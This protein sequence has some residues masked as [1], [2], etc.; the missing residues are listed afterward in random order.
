[1]RMTL[2]QRRR[3]VLAA[4]AIA[5]LPSVAFAQ[6]E[7]RP[8]R[9]AIMINTDLAAAKHLIDA[10]KEKMVERGWREGANI[11]YISREARGDNARLDPLAA[12]LV[13]LKPDL[14]LASTTQSAVAVK[15]YTSVIP[16]VFT[17]VADPV[18]AGLAAS[19]SRPG[20]NATGTAAG[21][22][23]GLNAKRLQI[24][25]EVFPAVRRVAVFHDPSDA[26]DVATVKQLQSAA[27]ELKLELEPITARRPEDFRA[28]FS[29]LKGQK[30]NVAIIGGSISN[31]LHR[32]PIADLAREHRI[33]TIY[34]NV[35]GVEAG[36][37]MS[38]GA[39]LATLYRHAARYADRILRGARPAELPVEQPP[40]VEL[41]INLKTARAL[42]IKFPQQILV[43]A[44]KVIE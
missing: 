6:P 1:D 27:T 4:G 13:G 37:L 2:G 9:V 43:R 15:K 14:I 22:G 25:K 5:I 31:F 32:K 40:I 21:F 23:E 20:G 8:V 11:N 26:Q 7:R 17:V 12:E 34:N 36:M 19:L 42:G 35:E 39:N 3:V 16:M 38:Y 18:A 29:R 41:A 30:L 10:F 44:D 28:S 33:A 24:L